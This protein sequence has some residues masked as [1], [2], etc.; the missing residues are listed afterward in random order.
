M[1][2]QSQIEDVEI[3]SD[4]DTSSSYLLEPLG[5]PDEGMDVE[6]EESI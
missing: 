1:A 3:K 6:M 4:I 5:K 2:I